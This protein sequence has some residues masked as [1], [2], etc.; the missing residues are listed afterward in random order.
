VVTDR[1][2]DRAAVSA[3]LHISKMPIVAGET[4]YWTTVVGD[5]HNKTYYSSA[6]SVELV[7]HFYAYSLRIN[8]RYEI[9]GCLH[10]W[11]YVTTCI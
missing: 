11:L 10:F 1:Q 9:D 7:V 6:L 5:R 8:L 3:S 4:H 2:A